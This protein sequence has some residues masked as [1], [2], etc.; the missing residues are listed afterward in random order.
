[1]WLPCSVTKTIMVTPLQGFSPLWMTV[2]E[3][4]S[5]RPN[6]KLGLEGLQRRSCT[7][8]YRKEILELETPMAYLQTTGNSNHFL[9]FW[10]INLNWLFWGRQLPIKRNN[11]ALSPSQAIMF[12]SN[13]LRSSHWRVAKLWERL[14]A[15]LRRCLYI[16]N[17]WNSCHLQKRAGSQ[18]DVLNT[19]NCLATICLNLLV[20]CRS[21]R[22]CE[23]LFALCT[24]TLASWFYFY[25][26]CTGIAG[27]QDMLP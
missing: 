3:H 5:Q 27:S 14:Q 4:R 25:T 21:L 12:P 2:L 6:F 7:E 26:G 1:M 9:F 19:Y 13:K 18:F 8:T 10:L 16:F 17:S 20:L 15:T 23:R 11:C 22:A 24:V